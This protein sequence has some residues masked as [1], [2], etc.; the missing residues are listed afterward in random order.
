METVLYNV[1]PNRVFNCQEF[2][3]SQGYTEKTC[4][5][6]NKNK[7]TTTKKRRPDPNV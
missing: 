7:K 2:Q 5:K 1:S 3:D 4:L 6:K